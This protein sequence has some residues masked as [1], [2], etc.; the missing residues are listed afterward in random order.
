M[1]SSKRERIVAAVPSRMSNRTGPTSSV[2]GPLVV[3]TGNVTAKSELQVD[4]VIEGDVRCTALVQGATSTITGMIEAQSV[5]LAGRVTGSIH[6]RELIILKSAVI[7]GDVH[8]EALTIEQGA[9]VDGRFAPDSATTPA[10]SDEGATVTPH[11]A[12]A[13]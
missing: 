1:L 5:R 11:L 7:T 3:I 10:Q 12:V 13:R 6:A 4:G 8:Y 2:I 9:S